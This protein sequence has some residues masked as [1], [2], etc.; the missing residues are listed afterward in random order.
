MD[1]SGFSGQV[2]TNNRNVYDQG[3]Q[4]TMVSG[5]LNNERMRKRQELREVG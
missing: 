3:F 4:N 2:L 1:S 5:N